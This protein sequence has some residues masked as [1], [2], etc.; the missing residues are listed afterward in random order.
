VYTSAK[1]EVSQRTEELKGAISLVD[2][3]VVAR[4]AA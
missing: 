4:Q 1:R 2:A 3:I